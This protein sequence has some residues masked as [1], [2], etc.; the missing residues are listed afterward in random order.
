M[1]IAIT[2]SRYNRKGGISRYIL[3][4]ASRLAKEHEVHIF[5]VSWSD[6]NTDKLI[7]HKVPVFPYLDIPNF[8]PFSSFFKRVTLFLEVLTF[9]L[10]NTL[11]FRIFGSKFDIIHTNGADSIYSDVVSAHSIYKAWRDYMIKSGQKGRLFYDPLIMFVEWWFYKKGQCKKI[12]ADAKT[13]KDELMEYYG[14]SEERIAVIPIGIDTEE[15]KPLPRDSL[16]DLRERYGIVDKDTVLFILATEFPRKGVP[17]LINAV[18]ILKNR[19]GKR[20]NL[21]IAGE[22]RP[23]GPDRYIKLADELGVSDNVIFA[24][25]VSGINRHY[26]LGDI[27]VFPT[28]YEGFGIPILE[29]MAAGLPVVTSRTGAG[30]LITD[31]L[32]GLILKNPNDPNEISEKI[33]LLID[34]ESLRKT[35]GKNARKTAERCNWDEITKK[36]MDVYKEI[37]KMNKNERG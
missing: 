23:Y 35:M 12:I 14:V 9:M 32:D 6:I 10:V 15:F 37:S 4:L 28:K 20:F 34:N 30:E 5:T 25:R 17:E 29:A 2:T 11:Y 16:S 7:F 3:E 13:G 19:V 21:L 8:I 31:G 36:T 24:G 26:N 18:A 22:G 1:K 33:G 27:F